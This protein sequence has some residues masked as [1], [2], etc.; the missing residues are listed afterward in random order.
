MHNLLKYTQHTHTHC[1]SMKNHIDN[2]RVRERESFNKEIVPEHR[3][4]LMFGVLVFVVLLS[5]YVWFVYV[6]WLQT[7][8]NDEYR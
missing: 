6:R 3:L 5:V 1:T 8:N 4:E 2:N 7:N